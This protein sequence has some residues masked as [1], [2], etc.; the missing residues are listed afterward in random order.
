MKPVLALVLVPALALA[1]GAPSA[2]PSPAEPGAAAPGSK[3]DHGKE[4]WG[5]MEKRMRLARAL[6]LA[7]ALDLD[8]AQAMK[9]DQVLV[10]FDARRKP[11]HESMR[12][13]MRVLHEA[14]HAKSGSAS[15]PT[16]DKAVDQAVAGIFDAREKL[17]AID[18]EMYQALS[19]GLSPE[20]RARMVLFFA[21]FRQEVRKQMME[22]EHMHG[23]DFGPG[24]RGHHPGGP[25]GSGWGE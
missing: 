6:G 22:H 25:P 13:S 15:A 14:A 9:M 5:R 4:H 7:E 17:Q 8:E 12:E 20:Q 19:K 16:T 11:L 3:H 10:S 18:R 24:M 2:P 23:H 1:Q 21:R